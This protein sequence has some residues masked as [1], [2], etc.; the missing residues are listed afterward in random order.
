MIN[1]EDKIDD[2]ISLI[3]K[4]MQF[5]ILNVPS[6]IE[7][8]II[9]IIWILVKLIF[10]LRAFIVSKI[11]DDLDYCNIFDYYI[12]NKNKYDINEF[13]I[14]NPELKQ[15][16]ENLILIKDKNKFIYYCIN[17]SINENM[18]ILKKILLENM[19]V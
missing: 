8:I 11:I 10:I 2:L 19:R 15:L 9:N 4:L 6:Y 7:N 13:D 14:E 16:Y 3:N 18:V 1:I 12:I 5:F 17:N